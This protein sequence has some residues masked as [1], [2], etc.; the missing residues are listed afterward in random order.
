MADPVRT[1]SARYMDSNYS[2]IMKLFRWY[3]SKRLTKIEK[4]YFSGV[5]TGKKFK[6]LK[7]YGFCF[8]GFGGVD[9]KIKTPS[10]DGSFHVIS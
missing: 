9:P 3:F 8:I 6:E 1:I 4:T 7:T 5:L 10:E 2:R